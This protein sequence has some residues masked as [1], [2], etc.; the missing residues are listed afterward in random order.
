MNTFPS[1]TQYYQMIELF[2]KANRNFL[3]DHLMLLE[4]RV[5]ERT[6]CG[7]LQININDLIKGD[8]FYEGYYVDVEYNRN[9]GRRGKRIRNDR[10]EKVNI[11]CDLIV[12]SR[13]KDL[14]QDNLIAIE[15]KKVEQRS[16]RK[17]E[18][19]VK[20]KERLMALTRPSYGEDWRYD[21][22]NLPDFVCRFIL[23]V[24]YEINYIN[25]KI[26]IQY[27]RSGEMVDDRVIDF[28]E[29]GL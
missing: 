21:G 5:S 20:D 13:G 14:E 16:L 24:Y 29:I 18:E 1:K 10:F 12:H 8:E 6:M 4:S 7:Q 26:Y 15:M 22:E 27:Y 17:E 11:N 19:I 3:N 28:A 23:G 2:E 25:R 9:V